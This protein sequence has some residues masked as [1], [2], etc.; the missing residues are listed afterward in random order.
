MILNTQADL[1]KYKSDIFDM[2][3]EGFKVHFIIK[4]HICPKESNLNMIINGE[5]PS[6]KVIFID[7]KLQLDVFALVKMFDTNIPVEHEN[8][9]TPSDT[10]VC[11]ACWK[12]TSKA[13]PQ[14]Y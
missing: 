3:N 13:K 5:V 4:D 11:P 1:K 6:L 14:M 8:D 7:P 9:R 12:E 2:Y 10:I